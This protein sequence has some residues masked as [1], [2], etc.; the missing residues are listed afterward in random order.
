MLSSEAKAANVSQPIR[1]VRAQGAGATPSAPLP[2][3]W[4]SWT[5]LQ[6]E[7]PNLSL[8]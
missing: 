4:L 5:H 7:S 8:R 3:H 1:L 2:A 6:V